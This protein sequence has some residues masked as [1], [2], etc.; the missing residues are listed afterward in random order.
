MLDIELQNEI[1]TSGKQ[2]RRYSTS[3]THTILYS[4]SIYGSKLERFELHRITTSGDD[5]FK[6]CIIVIT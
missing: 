5:E 1:K 3:E 2:T 6:G 4:F